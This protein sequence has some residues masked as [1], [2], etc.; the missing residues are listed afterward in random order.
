MTPIENEGESH[1]T[2]LISA[3]D[4]SIKFGK[5]PI[6]DKVSIKIHRCEIVTLIGLNGAGKSTLVRAIL[7]LSQLFAGKVSQMNGIRIGYVP[8]HINRD[9]I[10]PMTVKRFL[11]LGGPAS[12]EGLETV[13]EEV[14]A[15][16]ILDTAVSSIS[17]GELNRILLARALLRRPNLLV[18]DEPFS[19][20][21]ASGKIELY[22]LVELIRDRHRCGV[23]VVSHD[24]HFV[25]TS[26]DFLI[27][28]GKNDYCSGAPK[29]IISHPLFRDIFGYQLSEQILLSKH[30]LETKK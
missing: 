14:G 1:R 28:L 29:E 5:R 12:R 25:L 20:V 18:L 22:G 17:G 19:S 13:M 11:R 4:I 7:G 3:E 21:D 30:E 2:V 8:Q 26:S 27:C 24:L 16:A 9:S 10:L 6:L 23:L 15:G